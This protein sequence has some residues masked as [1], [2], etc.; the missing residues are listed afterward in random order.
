MDLVNPVNRPKVEKYANDWDGDKK[1]V[2]EQE[3]RK[4]KNRQ[5]LLDAAGQK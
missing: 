2:E 3:A 5:A 1:L 4:K